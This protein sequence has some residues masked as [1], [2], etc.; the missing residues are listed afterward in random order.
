MGALFLCPLVG[1]TKVTTGVRKSK[2]KHGILK[3]GGIGVKAAGTYLEYV[4]RSI[5]FPLKRGLLFGELN[6][7][8]EEVTVTA[9]E[10]RTCIQ[11]LLKGGHIAQKQTFTIKIEAF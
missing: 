7:V 9:R 2:Q 8:A 1:R 5:S 6:I 3:I 4:E 10:L 11:L